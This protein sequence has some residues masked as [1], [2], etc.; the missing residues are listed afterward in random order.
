MIYGTNATILFGTDTFLTGYARYAHPYDFYNLRF[1][2]SGAER[3]KNETRRLYSERFGVRIFEG[4]GATETAP[5]LALNTPMQNQVG[6]VGRLLPGITWRIEPVP[7]IETGGSLQVKGPNIMRGYLK[8]DN[9]GILQPPKDGWYDT[10]DVVDI[11]AEGYVVIKGRL[12]RFA[13]VG[14]EMISLVAVEAQVA[15]LWPGY[16]HAV[17]GLP[18]A[19]KGERLILV[20]DYQEAQRD[21]LVAFARKEKTADIAIPKVILKQTALP[22]L[23]AG[24]LDYVGIRNLAIAAITEQVDTEESAEED[25]DEGI[26]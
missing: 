20:T 24:K 15:R 23:S 2:F 7:G 10:G 21:A 8:I 4:Y 14:G 18:D 25:Q 9:P 5:V 1:I 3:L 26:V 11:D 22:I 16:T 13:K 17:V 19:K 12:K 6:S